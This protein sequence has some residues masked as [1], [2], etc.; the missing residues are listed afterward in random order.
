[1]KLFLGWISAACLMLVVTGCGLDGPVPRET[2]REEP[3]AKNQPSDQ[4]PAPAA[5]SAT[6]EKTTG[7]VRP[8][9][10]DTPQT[11]SSDKAE[12]DKPAG[13]TASPDNATNETKSGMEREKAAVGVGEKG[14]GYGGG[15]IT[16]S[17]HLLF[18][19]K[20]KIYFD[21]MTKGLNEYRAEHDGH[22]PKTEA[23]FFEKIIKEYR[24]Q[25]PA[26]PQGERYV[27]DPEKG[28]LMVERKTSP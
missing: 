10:G 12:P 28:D 11:A 26:L 18:T 7:R 9:R 8:R 22:P 2:A 6:P 19:A 14:R 17:V 20:E 15:V 27:Y 21:Q 4:K 1:M 25:L 13:N 3:A 16:T 5:D 24:I 23:E